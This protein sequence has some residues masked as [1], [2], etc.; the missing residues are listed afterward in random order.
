MKFKI[1]RFLVYSLI[2]VTIFGN[3]F[4]NLNI[5]GKYYLYSHIYFAFR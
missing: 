3:D 1:F 5:S 2:I 4:E